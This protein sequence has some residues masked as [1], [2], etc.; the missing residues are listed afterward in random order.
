MPGV[1]LPKVGLGGDNVI[2]IIEAKSFGDCCEACG[3]LGTQCV[4]WTFASNG[5]DYHKGKGKC[6]LRNAA[7]TVIAMYMEIIINTNYKDAFFIPI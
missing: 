5:G 7:G 4:S 2:K 3:D 1:T 6:H